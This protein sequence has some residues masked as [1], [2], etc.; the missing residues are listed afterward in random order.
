MAKILFLSHR[1]PYPPNKGEKIRAYHFLRHIAEHHD[2]FL[3]S[4]NDEMPDPLPVSPF[5]A[6]CHL[7]RSFRLGRLEKTARMGLA[8]ATG[9]ALS[10]AAFRHNGLA[11]WCDEIC[12]R[13]RPDL[14]FA[15]SSAMAQYATSPAA[16]DIPLVIDFVD[17]DSEKFRQYAAGRK[18][19]VGL[20]YAAEAKRLLRF[21]CWAAS[22]AKA[23]MFVSKTELG[24]FEGLCPDAA[25]KLHAVPNGIDCDYFDPT[26]RAGCRLPG[27]PII[28]FTGRMDYPPNVEAA[29][30]FAR[31]IFPT[32]R[33]AVP[34]ARFQIVGAAPSPRITA[35]AAEPAVEVTGAVPDMRPYYL[36]AT[37]AVAPLKIARGIQNKV[38]EAMAMALPVVA[39]PAALDGISARDG[40]HLLVA[41]DAPAFARAVIE[42]LAGRAPPGLGERARA[43]MLAH[44]GW[45]AQ[46]ALLDRVI[47]DAVARD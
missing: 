4:L 19:P 38:L 3:G 33:V 6:A 39:T 37:L 12:A 31:E 42:I 24:L 18:D 16:R 41:G 17:V 23:A 9:R 43:Q 5:V 45:P 29:T 27:A 28:L 44:H 40:E 25:S 2:V 8:A 30:W 34:N 14:V 20:L 21:D 7:A 11:R 15:F 26:P 10:V 46:F 36:D 13:A 32:V 22:H 1:V 47:A 35:L